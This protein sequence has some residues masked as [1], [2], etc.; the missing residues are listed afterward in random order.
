VPIDA[1]IMCG[2]ADR[3]PISLPHS[4]EVRPAANAAAEPPDEPPGD[5]DGFHGLFVVP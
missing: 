3:A 2:I 5:N 4:S 1:A